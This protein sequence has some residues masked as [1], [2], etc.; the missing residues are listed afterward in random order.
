MSEPRPAWSVRQATERDLEA[1]VA[2][3]GAWSTSAGWSRAAFA[4]ELA[5]ER[6]IFRVLEEAGRVLGFACMR[7]LAPVAELLEIA[8]ARDAARRGVGRRLLEELHREARAAG[9]SAA[10]LEVRESNAA[11]LELYARFGYRVVGRRPKYYN[12]IDALLMEAPL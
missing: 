7:V 10:H 5:A 3:E 4:A 8:V 6:S 9:C 2:I 1:I 11:A 12:G